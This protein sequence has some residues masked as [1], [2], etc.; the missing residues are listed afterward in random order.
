MS[1]YKNKKLVYDSNEPTTCQIHNQVE[2]T[3]VDDITGFINELKLNSILMRSTNKT[4]TFQN[5]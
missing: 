2:I 5:E 1:L 4:V 3:T